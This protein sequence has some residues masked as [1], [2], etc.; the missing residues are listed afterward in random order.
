VRKEVGGEEGKEGRNARHRKTSFGDWLW[1]WVQKKRNRPHSNRQE[2][3][4]RKYMVK[5]LW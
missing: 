4:R 3:G 2:G 1:R 5:S